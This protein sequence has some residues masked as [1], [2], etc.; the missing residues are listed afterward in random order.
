MQLNFNPIS[1]KQIPNCGSNC[2][3]QDT[4]L[5]QFVFIPFDN[6][7]LRWKQVTPV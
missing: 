1:I 3:I 5:L 6:S 4:V 7:E 2:Y